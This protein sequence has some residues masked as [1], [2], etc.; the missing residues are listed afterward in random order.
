MFLERAPV[1]TRWEAGWALGVGLNVMAEAKILSLL[2]IEHRLS[3]S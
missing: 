3:G 2:E 1:S